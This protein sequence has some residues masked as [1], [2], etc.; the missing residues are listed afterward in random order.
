MNLNDVSIEAF[1]YE[2]MVEL[3]G[4]AVKVGLKCVDGKWEF[5][6]TLPLTGENAKE[7]RLKYT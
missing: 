7:R 4:V 3:V 2:E 5:P 1:K 6:P